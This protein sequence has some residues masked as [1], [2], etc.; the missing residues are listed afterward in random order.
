MNSFQRWAI[1]ALAKQGIQA[2]E[3]GNWIEVDGEDVMSEQGVRALLSRPVRVEVP[4]KDWTFDKAQA[5]VRFLDGRKG[6][7]DASTHG[8]AARVEGP[9]SHADAENLV[10]GLIREFEREYHGRED[11]PCVL[12]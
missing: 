3:K 7:V 6:V 2:S 10:F 8:P 1:D 4:D 12:E 9:I 11:D 5:F